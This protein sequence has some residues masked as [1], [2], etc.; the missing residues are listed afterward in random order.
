MS[1]EDEVSGEEVSISE[2]DIEILELFRL[3]SAENQHVIFDQIA[4]LSFER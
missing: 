1:D 4:E 2:K 3:L